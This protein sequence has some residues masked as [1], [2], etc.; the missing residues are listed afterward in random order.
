MKMKKLV[1]SSLSARQRSLRKSLSVCIFRSAV[2]KVDGKICKLREL[3]L[4]CLTAFV[5]RRRRRLIFRLFGD[6]KR[7][8][9]GSLK[10]DIFRKSVF[11]SFEERGD[12][13]EISK[14]YTVSARK[15]EIFAVK[16]VAALSHSTRGSR[17]GN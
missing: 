8:R 6:G 4:I 16:N 12:A 10:Y 14:L 15:E 9:G 11:F 17:G 7:E 5:Q 3:Q 1:V 13:L 2:S